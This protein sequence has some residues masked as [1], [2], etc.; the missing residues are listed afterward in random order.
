METFVKKLNTIILVICAFISSA[1]C[2]FLLLNESMDHQS[3]PIYKVIMWA[4]LTAVIIIGLLEVIKYSQIKVEW[5]KSLHVPLWM[6]LISVFLGIII[7]GIMFEK[8]F[9]NH[10]QDRVIIPSLII[11]ASNMIYSGLKWSIIKL[12][13]LSLR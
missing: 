6:N 8:V 2:S 4:I 7:C 9:S 1:V 13:E 11:T 3:D 12:H 5:R 10:P